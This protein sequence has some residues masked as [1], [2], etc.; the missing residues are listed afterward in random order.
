MSLEPGIVDANILIYA[1]DADA[2]QHAHRV[3]YSKRLVPAQQG[4]T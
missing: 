2:P 3:L 1:M 4:F